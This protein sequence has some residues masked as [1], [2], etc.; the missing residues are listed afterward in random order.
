VEHARRA[1]ELNLQV[2][3]LPKPFYP[4]LPRKTFL[5]YTLGLANISLGK[6]WIT[7]DSTFIIHL[8]YVDDLLR[9]LRATWKL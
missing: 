4:L 7:A 8:W 1:R 5:N 9:S 2:W 3:A 6:A